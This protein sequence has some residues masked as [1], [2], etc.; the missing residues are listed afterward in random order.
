MGCCDRVIEGLQGNG[1]VEE[2]LPEAIGPE[3]SAFGEN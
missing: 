3:I 2:D 1:E